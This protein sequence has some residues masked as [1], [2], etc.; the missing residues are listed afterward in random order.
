MKRYHIYSPREKHVEREILVIIEWNLLKTWNV[1]IAV[2]YTDKLI[3]HYDNKKRNSEQNTRLIC[4]PGR[5]ETEQST[6]F[7]DLRKS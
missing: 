5:V 3:M 6:I 4:T 7:I 2:D 1:L